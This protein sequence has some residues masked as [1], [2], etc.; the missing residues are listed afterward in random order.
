MG[1]KFRIHKQFNKLFEIPA[2]NSGHHFTQ[3]ELHL[4]RLSH[5]IR[6]IN[7]ITTLRTCLE[8]LLENRIKYNKMDIENKKINIIHKTQS[9]EETCEV[10]MNIKRSL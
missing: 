9:T 1:N 5:Q 3:K 6:N 8:P 10:K 2:P 7:A 4:I